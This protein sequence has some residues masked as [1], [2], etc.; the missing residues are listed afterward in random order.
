[1]EIQHLL[2][3][4]GIPILLLASACDREA[5][6]T[7][8]D[9]G[10]TIEFLSPSPGAEVETGAAVWLHVRF[11]ET[12]ELHE[13]R[14]ILRSEEHANMG[15]LFAGHSHEKVHEVEKEIA[16]PAMP[17]TTFEFVAE[18]SDHEGNVST[19]SVHVVMTQ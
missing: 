19:A 9:A 8:D 3:I 14:I 6:A 18:A 7:V 16:L 1:M 13:M 5:E 12:L 4:I 15:V 2:L 10:P 17:G 11:S